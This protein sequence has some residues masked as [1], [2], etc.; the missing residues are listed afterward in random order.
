MPH[1]IKMKCS[2]FEHQNFQTRGHPPFEIWLGMVTLIFAQRLIF[3]QDRIEIYYCQRIILKFYES[4]NPDHFLCLQAFAKKRLRICFSFIRTAALLQFL[5]ADHFYALCYILLSD[6]LM[7]WLGIRMAELRRVCVWG[8]ISVRHVAKQ[9]WDGLPVVR[10]SY[11][12]RKHHADINATN[13][14][15]VLHSKILGNSVCHNHR[16]KAGVVNPLQCW[17]WKDP[18][19]ENSIDFCCSCLE[20]LASSQ[21]DRPTS[22]CHVVH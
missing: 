17:S 8:L 21:A 19:C 20:Q 13:L 12:L 7:S 11:C 4:R 1:W 14:V 10:P 3:L 18:M 2:S 15:T 22:V 5:E 9:I 16:F 6:C